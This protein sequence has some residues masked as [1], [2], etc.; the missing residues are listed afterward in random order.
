MKAPHRHD[1]DTT[2]SINNEVKVF[3]KK[4][5]KK[6]KM[7]YYAKVIETNLSKEHLPST[8]YI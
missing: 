5:S 2:S 8:D 1:L 3:N 6:M 7:Y 4:L